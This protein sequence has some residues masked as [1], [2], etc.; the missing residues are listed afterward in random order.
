MKFKD[1]FIYSPKQ[2]TSC[3]DILSAPEKPEN[4][5]GKNSYIKNNIQDK[6][7]HTYKT[8]KVSPT[9]SENLAFINDAFETSKNF[10]L[11]VREFKVRLAGS[12]ADAFLIFYDGL[13][14]KEYVNRDILKPLMQQGIDK[15]QGSLSDT[16]YQCLLTQAPNTMQTEMQAIIE[17]VGF[18][19]CAVFVDG[20][21]CAFVADIKGWSSRSV[22]RPVAE[23]VLT[24]PQEA[25]CEAVMPN[26]ALVRKILKDPNLIAENITAGTISK[27]PCA[28]MYINGITN[29][30]LVAE[31]RRRLKEIEVEYI[32]SSTDIEMFMEES[33]LFPLP[34]ILKTERPDRA[35]AMLSDGKVVIMVQGSPFVLVL[36][37]TAHD[38]A[39]TAEDN[40]VRT[41]E[42]NFMKL[43][44]VLGCALALLLPGSFLSIVLYH[45]ESI[46]TDLLLAIEASRKQMPF[47][48]TLE[49]VIMALAFELIKEASIRVPDPIG[50]TL[51]IVGGLILGQSA[52]SANIASPLLIIIVSISALGAF[53]APSASISRALSVLQF[54]F[55]F[56]GA[57]AG[58]LGIAFGLFTGTLYLASTVTFGVPYLSGEAWG[59]GVPPIWKREIRPHNLHTQQ[60]RKQPHISRK[61]K[62]DS[63]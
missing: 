60:R 59:F 37:A 13:A 34:Q 58:F 21:N 11:V 28:L 2:E 41:S 39:E 20:C 48:I 16:I 57:V 8:G 32:F 50:S 5:P 45:H 46:P 40:Y 62:G 12:F 29:K 49:L 63:Q 25:F 30:S 47:P 17:A 26:I 24:G 23:A 54:V 56:L 22:G 10:D 3:P 1:L 27:T 4:N 61:W 9:L 44:R 55:V 35:A 6:E 18:G 51:G 53:A 19:N 42:A 36:P 38:L 43:V 52:V 31:A 15:I 7:T 14:N 33:T